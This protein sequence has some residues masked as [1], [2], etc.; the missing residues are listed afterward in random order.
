MSLHPTLIILLILLK[1]GILVSSD[2]VPLFNAP[3]WL[4]KVACSP[5]IYNCGSCSCVYSKTMYPC[6]PRIPKAPGHVIKSALQYTVLCILSS[7]DF[8]SV[9]RQMLE[10]SHILTPQVA[11]LSGKTAYLEAHSLHLREVGKEREGEREGEDR[12][13]E[14]RDSGIYNWLMCE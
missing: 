6:F 9:M 12:E 4:L 11:S 1:Y 8:W 3:N 7:W 10:E 14:R 5:S 2:F 13:G